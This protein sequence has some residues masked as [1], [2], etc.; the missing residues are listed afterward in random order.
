MKKWIAINCLALLGSAAQAEVPPYSAT[1][2]RIGSG[3][4]IAFQPPANHHFND[5]SPWH[6]YYR[7]S[8]D[9]FHLA[10]DSSLSREKAS[11][12][13]PANSAELKAELFLCD[14]GNTYCVPQ[15]QYYAI[16][17][18]SLKLTKSQ[19]GFS[20]LGDSNEPAVAATPKAHA[21]AKEEGVDEH[22]FFMNNP[23]KALEISKSEKRPVMIDFFGVWCPP[24]NMLDETVFSAPEFQKTAQRFVKL[25][26]D[27]DDKVSWPLKG[28]YKVGGYPTVVF[29][30]ATGD[31]ILRVVGSRSKQDFIKQVQ[32]ALQFEDKP[33]G[34]LETQAEKGEAKA[35]KR[36]AGLWLERHQYDAAIKYF[37]KARSL[38]KTDF[39]TKD[40]R[41]LL[42]AQIGL[43]QDAY[44]EAQ[45]TESRNPSLVQV[46]RSSFKEKLIQGLKHFPT[47]LDTIDWG[48]ALAG[49]GDDE[50]DKDL[51]KKGYEAMLAAAKS[52]LVSPGALK[53]EEMTRAD[54]FEIMGEAYENLGKLPQSKEAFANAAREYEKTIRQQKLPLDKERGFNLERAYSLSKSG[55]ASEA[56]ALYEKL[57]KTYPSEFTFWFAHAS[58][59]KRQKDW[60]AAEPLARKAV[61]YSYGDNKLRAVEL[62][63]RALKEDGRAAEAKTLLGDTLAHTQLPDDVTIRTHRYYKSLKKLA[64]ELK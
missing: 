36:L 45:N 11:V 21:A 40:E 14:N 12:D 23:E 19:T 16:T 44:K 29:A 5:E 27:A 28:K 50:G 52:N 17:G 38:K 18:K 62:L 25:K 33:I 61:E 55:L 47:S 8:H 53:G 24:C 48:E 13:I 7:V 35:S 26:L 10:T 56:Q 4:H 43:S 58:F 57:E 46:T 41:K 32:E 39:S 49:I 42:V 31:E 54:L 59:M 37:E 51:T 9:P 63:A 1:L 60:K 2:S 64:D 20:A 34:V 30:T 6:I 3:Y 15:V 22:G